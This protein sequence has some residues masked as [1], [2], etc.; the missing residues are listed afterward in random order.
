MKNPFS[1]GRR[2]R[3]LY[4][5]G[6]LTL[7]AA[8]L[9]YTFV[10]PQKLAA[11]ETASAGTS[12][13]TAADNTAQ[14][15][16]ATAAA[17]VTAT[18]YDDGNISITITTERIDDTEVYIADITLSDISYLKTAL[19]QSTYGRNIKETTSDMAEEN[20]A[21]LAINGD[22]YGFRD[23]GYVLRN[24][25]LYRDTSAGGEDL[26]ILSD[27]SFYLFDEDDITAEE[28]QAMG[29]LQIFS[30][31]PALVENGSVAVSASEEVSQAMTSNPRTAI[32]IVSPLHYVI[33]V[34]DGRT[35]ESSGLSLYQLAGVFAGLG[36]TEAYNLDGGG[37]STL[38]FCGSVVNN[39]TG[40]AAGNGSSERKV[41]D[42]VYIG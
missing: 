23:S 21:I 16:A 31:G 29:A 33:V 10:I 41:S 40:G 7:A 9:L 12:A 37:S 36:C 32:G 13:S 19:A 35:S 5:T 25:T 2:F 27:G 30:F 38:W 34:S 22:Y 3:A 6:T 15:A 14:T 42:I 28:V 18:S 24:G 1:F 26:A 11:V 39:P 20:N 17:V 8:L 4:C